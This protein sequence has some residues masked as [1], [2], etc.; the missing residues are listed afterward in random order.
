VAIKI[1]NRYDKY[2]PWKVVLKCIPLWILKHILFI[3]ATNLFGGGS[4]LI[5]VVKILS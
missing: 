1:K 2:V 3:Y 4:N 5:K